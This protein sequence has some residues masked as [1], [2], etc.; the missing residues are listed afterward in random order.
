METYPS[1]CPEANSVRTAHIV[2]V[3]NKY[4]IFANSYCGRNAF[5]PIR[6]EFHIYTY[7]EMKG[8]L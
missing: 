3:S 8:I 6:M 7:N 2:N 4:L 5:G 1:I